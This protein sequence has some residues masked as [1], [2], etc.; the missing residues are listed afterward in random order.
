VV[1][2]LFIQLLENTGTQRVDTIDA[3][4]KALKPDPRLHLPK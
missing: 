3:D 4:F 2:L 1:K